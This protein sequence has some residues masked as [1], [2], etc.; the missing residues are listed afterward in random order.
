MREQLQFSVNSTGTVHLFIGMGRSPGKS[1]FMT[2]TL[3]Y[4]RN[5]NH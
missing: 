4:N 5:I 1:T 2:L 3:I